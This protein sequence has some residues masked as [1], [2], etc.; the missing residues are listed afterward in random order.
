MLFEKKGFLLL[1]NCKNEKFPLLRALNNALI[2]KT[3]GE[4]IIDDSGDCD[5]SNY[6]TRKSPS[7]PSSNMSND[8]EGDNLPLPSNSGEYEKKRKSEF[9][10]KISFLQL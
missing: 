8:L 4:E 6:V 3:N 2:M 1:G 7:N 10:E 5:A 9:Y